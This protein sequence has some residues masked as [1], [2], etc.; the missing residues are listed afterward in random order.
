MIHVWWCHS[1]LDGVTAGSLSSVA[2]V[3]SDLWG[4]AG[5]PAHQEPCCCQSDLHIR[6][7]CKYTHTYSSLVNVLF[8]QVSCC[9][10]Q[11]FDT[12]HRRHSVGWWL[13][14][15]PYLQV[16][17]WLNLD[18][19]PSAPNS[20]KESLS[21]ERD[22]WP[23]DRQVCSVY[24]I[25]FMSEHNLWLNTDACVTLLWQTCGSNVCRVTIAESSKWK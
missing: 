10:K 3:T 2:D 18:G 14:W 4:V 8:Y 5:S 22:R 16:V 21:R 11:I 6:L 12:V 13:C 17:L 20:S 15:V 19:F 1:H 25:F 9:R 24:L 23:A 7:W